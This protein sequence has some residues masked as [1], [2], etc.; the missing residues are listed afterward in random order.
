MFWFCALF[1]GIGLI[2]WCFHRGGFL[3]APDWTGTGWNICSLWGCSGCCD[4]GSPRL[5]P[6]D[7]DIDSSR[8][9]GWGVWGFPCEGL[10]Y[11]FLPKAYWFRPALAIFCMVAHSAMHSRGSGTRRLTVNGTAAIV[12][13]VNSTNAWKELIREWLKMSNSKRVIVTLF[14]TV[15]WLC[16]QRAISNPTLY[17]CSRACLFVTPWGTCFWYMSDQIVV[18][19]LGC[20]AV[21]HFPATDCILDV[22]S[23]HFSYG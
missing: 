17:L 3:G 23:S 12:L 2:L 18:G 16:W 13:W 4:D 8:G 5:N 9:A 21:F 20:V 7:W 19:G 14:D 6:G 11:G 1:V 10:F 15:P 22:L